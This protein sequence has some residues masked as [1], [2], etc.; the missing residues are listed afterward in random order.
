[1]S[2]VIVWKMND[3]DSFCKHA[4]TTDFYLITAYLLET[5]CVRGMIYMYEWKYYVLIEI[6]H[7]TKI[8]ICRF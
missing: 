4:T 5:I 3:K 8:N 6:L 1:M 7:D 2:K